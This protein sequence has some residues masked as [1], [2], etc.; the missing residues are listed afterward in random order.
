MPIEWNGRLLKTAGRY[1]SDEFRGDRIELSAK[2]LTD[3]SKAK[4]LMFKRIFRT[5]VRDSPSRN[6]PCSGLAIG[7]GET[8]STSWR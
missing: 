5:I 4:R 8:Q 1:F 3:G 6:V 2:V 7:Q